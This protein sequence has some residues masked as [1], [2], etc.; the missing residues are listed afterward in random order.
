MF[1]IKITLK[2]KSKNGKRRTG[3]I[4]TSLTLLIVSQIVGNL[5]FSAGSTVF[6]MSVAAAELTE[7]YL[8]WREKKR[9]QD[10]E[11]GDEGEQ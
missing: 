6:A 3:L 1:R 8:N 2:D 10:E 5:Y 7:I 11:E 9:K 4:L